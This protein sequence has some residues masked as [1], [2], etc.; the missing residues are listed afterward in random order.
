MIKDSFISKKNSTIL[1]IHYRAHLFN[2]TFWNI[3]KQSA[4]LEL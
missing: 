4:T 3:S 2:D 1:Q